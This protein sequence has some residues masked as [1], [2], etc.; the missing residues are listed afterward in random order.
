MTPTDLLSFSLS[1]FLVVLPVPPA[2]AQEN[3][4]KLVANLESRNRDE[5][6]RAAQ[7][8]GEM[9]SDAQAAVPALVKVIKTGKPE[10]RIIS[11]IALLKIDPFMRDMIPILLRAL[12]KEGQEQETI[13]G[14]EIGLQEDALSKWSNLMRSKVDPRILPLL[15]KALQEKDKDIRIL[16]VLVL[17]GVAAQLPEAL[18]HVLKA[19]SD[20]DPEVRAAAVGALSRIGP[21][22][23]GVV[24]GILAGMRDP[25]PEVRARTVLA[26]GRLGP[27]V[28]ETVPA[29]LGALDDKDSRVRTAVLKVLESFGG[30]AREA[31]PAAAARVERGEPEERLAAV[32][33][34]IKMDPSQSGRMVPLRVLFLGDP[35]PAIRSGAMQALVEMRTVPPELIPS[36]S[37]ALQDKERPIRYLAAEGLGSLGVLAQGAIPALIQALK[38]PEESIRTSA[39]NALL[40]DG[41]AGGGG[42]HAGRFRLQRSSSAGQGL[43]VAQAGSP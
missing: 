7:A 31:A 24:P 1:L 39:G 20:L 33:A 22:V 3:I 28:P 16:G 37:A 10:A 12:E 32:E 26:L 2:C 30:A 11:S 41:G 18:P 35:N 4:Q 36:L 27:G 29:L 34:T 6:L 40:E 42:D 14:R 13:L 8:L 23:E 38:D 25:E 5:Q 17:G 21:R 43:P 19:Y 15:V 9:G